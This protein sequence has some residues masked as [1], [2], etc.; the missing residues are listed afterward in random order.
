MTEEKAMIA[1][2]RHNEGR[3]KTTTD[4][5]ANA[6]NSGEAATIVVVAGDRG[7]RCLKTFTMAMEARS[8]KFEKRPQDLRD[9]RLR[10]ADQ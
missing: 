6:G 2:K 3:K 8:P 1:S 5:A 4:L 10:P 9:R 7:R